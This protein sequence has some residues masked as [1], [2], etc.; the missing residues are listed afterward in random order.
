M[1]VAQRTEKTAMPQTVV[2]ENA[3]STVAASPR[4]SQARRGMQTA[5]N[6]ASFGVAVLAVW[7]LI[8]ISGLVP[9]ILLPG[10]V[11]VAQET[12]RTLVGMATG[13]HVLES[14]W[15]T[16]SEILLGFVLAIVVGFLLGCLV[17]ETK[18]G[19]NVVMPYLVAINVMPKVAFAP[20]FVAW[21]GFGISSKVV[22]AAF[23]AFFPIIV[24]TAAGLASVERNKLMLFQSLGASRW[25]T[26]LKLKLPGALPHIFA[27]VKTA[28]V[29]VV[30]GAVVGEYLG[31]GNGLG[32]LIKL[33]ASQLR[34]DRVFAMI[35]FLSVVGLV[36]YA[37]VGRVERKVVFWRHSSH[38]EINGS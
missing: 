22:M 3:G 33:S 9:S 11:D 15:I 21:F 2:T 16:T 31:G 12:W 35:I 24:D 27:G 7:H 32:E 26:L 29:L 8:A 6:L 13:D 19:T 34:L 1:A 17:G 23:I 37:L 25:Q 18:F 28:A 38:F 36:L 14:L 30:V 10:P 5:V 4:R 20:V